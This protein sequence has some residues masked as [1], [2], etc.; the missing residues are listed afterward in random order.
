ME[1]VAASGSTLEFCGFWQSQHSP[2]GWQACLAMGV[3]SAS[4]GRGAALLLA[5]AQRAGRAPFGI[6]AESG[7]ERSGL[8]RDLTDAA[9]TSC[10]ILAVNSWLS[11]NSAGDFVRTGSKGVSLNVWV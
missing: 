5:V 2:L 6:A 7:Q 8:R 3:R 4:T 10:P 11:Y 9:A 1:T